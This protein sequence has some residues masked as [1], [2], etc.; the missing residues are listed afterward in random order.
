M[1]KACGDGRHG[2]VSTRTRKRLA[3]PH[4]THAGIGGARRGP[5]E[6]IGFVHDRLD[7]DE[8]ALRRHVHDEPVAGAV[9]LDADAHPL[10][11]M[12]EL[13]GA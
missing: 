5:V 3:G 1:A 4:H 2:G 12:D 6:R 13:R 7:R 8:V 11:R 10:R 9:G